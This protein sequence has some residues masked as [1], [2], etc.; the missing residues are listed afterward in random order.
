MGI[1]NDD[2][3]D[4]MKSMYDTCPEDLRC[5]LE[6]ADDLTDEQL[7]GVTATL[8]TPEFYGPDGHFDI[9][10]VLDHAD[11]VLAT[12]RRLFPAHQEDQ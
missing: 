6:V 12:A 5:L 8:M 4:L 9:Q 7:E 3:L 11:H 1:T 10:R 2:L